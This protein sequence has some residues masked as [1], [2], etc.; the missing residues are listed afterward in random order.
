MLPLTARAW[1]ER[2][3]G[4]SGGQRQ[5]LAIA[6]VLLSKPAIILLDEVRG[7]CCHLRLGAATR[8]VLTEARDVQTL[9]VL[10][11]RRRRLRWT[12]RA[13]RL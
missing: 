7:S 9:M 8:G 10:S 6:R 5:R 4:L 2:R 12:R 3:A 1:A 13:K 11:W